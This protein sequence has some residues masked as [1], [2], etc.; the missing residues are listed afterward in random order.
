MSLVGGLGVGVFLNF[1]VAK[2]TLGSVWS[3][4][5]GALAGCLVAQLAMSLFNVENV[6]LVLLSSIIGSAILLISLDYLVNTVLHKRIEIVELQKN[7]ILIFLSYRRASTA[8][9]TERIYDKLVA[10]FKPRIIFKDVNSIPAGID[11]RKHIDQSLN[12]TKVFVLIMGDQWVNELEESPDY[13]QIEIETA[14]LHGVPIVP[15]LIKKADMPDENMLPDAIKSVVY[16]NAVRVRSDPD[17]ENDVDRLI[18]A[19]I[20][21]VEVKE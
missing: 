7:E 5:I 4:S 6:A 19:I 11:F 21:Q 13:V 18:G 1:I 17:F 3:M 15:V 20:E 14:L 12:K 8:D 2:T 16:R 10:S 9:I